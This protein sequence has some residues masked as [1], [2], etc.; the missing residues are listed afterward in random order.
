MSPARAAGEVAITHPERVVYP[1]S[2]LTKADVADYYRAVSRWLLP[3][4]VRR[5]LSLLRCPD[6]VGAECFFQKHLGRGLGAHVHEVPLKQKS[7]VEDYLYIEDLAGLLELVQMNSLELHPWGA[8]VDDP[9][10]PDQLV[11]D[12]DPG[13]GVGWRE[14]KL[15]ARHIRAELR[16]F[17]L[18]SFVR[19]SGGKGLHVVAPLR[20]RAGWDAAREFADLLAHRLAERHPDRYV[21]T[22][23]KAKR[24]GVIFIDWLRNARGATSV[25]SWSLRAREHA[26]VAM[27]LRWEELSRIASPQAF[28]LPKARQRAARLKVHPWGDWRK[29]KQALPE[30]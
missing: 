24:E 29:L 4:V 27:P 20:P 6:G 18:E 12:L 13:E 1:A 5:P 11:F 22:M 3:E 28:P 14:V 17:G 23:S 7:G 9:E 2:G 10:H 15:G 25:C 16:H 19:L 26:A 8:T 30:R 21:A